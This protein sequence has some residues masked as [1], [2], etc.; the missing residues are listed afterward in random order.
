MDDE[1]FEQ[2]CRDTCVALNQSDIDALTIKHQ[3][4]VD[5]VNIGLFFD[6]LHT[7]D[8]IVCYVE[9][10]DLPD[11]DREEILE[12]LLAINLL[13]GSKTSGVYG[14]DRMS[15]KII[16]VQHFLYPELLTGQILSEILRGYAHHAKATHMSFLDAANHLPLP[17]LLE[18]SLHS[19]GVSFA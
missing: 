2:L 4:K 19:Q 3:I 8:R 10:G 15:E 7:S 18:Q 6:A 5:G 14:L 13:T 16:F 1:L 9:I 11:L 12:R 17:D